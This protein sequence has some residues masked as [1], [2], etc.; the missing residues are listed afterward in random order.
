MTTRRWSLVIIHLLNTAEECLDV[1]TGDNATITPLCS[2]RTGKPWGGGWNNGRSRAV[3]GEVA[4]IKVKKENGKEKKKSIYHGGARRC[5]VEEEGSPA[6]SATYYC[7][8][9]R[10]TMAAILDMRKYPP[11]CPRPS[12]NSPIHPRADSTLPPPPPSTTHVP[13]IRRPSLTE[14]PPCLPATP[15][16]F[17]SQGR[18]LSA[19]RGGN[20]FFL[21][22][23][24]LSRFFFNF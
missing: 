14:L 4:I 5:R 18:R 10:A 17:Q 19:N 2:L 12:T 9:H 8:D 15:T 16:F 21:S 11:H 6:A 3:D 1:R 23:F 20:R 22:S 7:F 13:P 24:W